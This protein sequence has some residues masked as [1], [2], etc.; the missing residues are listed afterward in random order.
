MSS[1]PLLVPVMPSPRPLNHLEQLE[2]AF[3]GR[4]QAMRRVRLRVTDDRAGE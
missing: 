1:P 2:R 4:E 3:F